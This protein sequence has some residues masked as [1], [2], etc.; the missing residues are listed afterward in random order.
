MSNPRTMNNHFCCF[1]CGE[2][3]PFN[4]SSDEHIIP[5]CLG[6]TLNKTGTKSVCAICNKKAGDKIDLPFCRDW[7]IETK[8][9]FQ[10]VVSRGKRPI[11]KFGRINWSR[12]EKV[13][14]YFLE[15][16]VIARAFQTKNNQRCV[17][18]GVI[19]QPPTPETQTVVMKAI[20]D[21][22]SGHKIVDMGG[23]ET[24]EEREIISSIHDLGQALNLNVSFD[25]TAWDRAV[26]KMGLGLTCLYLGEDFA[27]SQ[28][29][30]RLRSFL[31]EED[32]DKRDEIPLHGSAGILSQRESKL[33][34][35]FHEDKGVHAFCLME[36]GNK[37]GFYTSLFGEHENF[38]EIDATGTFCGRL[39]GTLARGVVW[40]VDPNKKTTTDPIPVEE[41]IR[42]RSEQRR[43]AAEKEFEQEI[44]MRK[45]R[46]ESP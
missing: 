24:D 36:L 7:F 5:A 18:F 16:N 17:M 1:Y 27:R 30:D 22:F 8:R 38:L 26:V 39:P 23:E 40:I 15:H 34:Q 19:G 43:L 33:S 32:P 20:K 21:R 25:I 31:W 11:T 41:L 37:I 3:F 35:I 44:Q 10:G 14:V 46:K 12:P 28:Q 13:D 45:D 42:R 29:A 9:F 2:T 4:K 6:A